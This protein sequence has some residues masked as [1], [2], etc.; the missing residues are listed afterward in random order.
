MIFLVRRQAY[1]GENTPGPYLQTPETGGAGGS[2][3]GGAATNRGAG[4]SRATTGGLLEG[5][6]PVA[7]LKSAVEECIE[8]T[9]ELEA[10]GRDAGLSADVLTLY[11]LTDTCGADGHSVGDLPLRGRWQQYTTSTRRS[12]A[13]RV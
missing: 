8:L 1:L 4:Q 3:D 6:G 11:P 7:R 10:V 2:R 12:S 5:G 9:R 13:P